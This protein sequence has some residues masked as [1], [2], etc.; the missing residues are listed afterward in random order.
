MNLLTKIRARRF[1]RSCYNLLKNEDSTEDQV[2]DEFLDEGLLQ[3]QI[4]QTGNYTLNHAQKQ[5]ERETIS[6]SGRDHKEIEKA[7]LELAYLK[8]NFKYQETF[9]EFKGFFQDRDTPRENGEENP[10]S[11]FGFERRLSTLYRFGISPKSVSFLYLA[12]DHDLL[13][14]LD[15]ACE[16][17]TQDKYVRVCLSV[18]FKP[19][20]ITQIYPPFTYKE[21][22]G[23]ESQVIQYI[24]DLKLKPYERLLK[25]DLRVKSLQLR[26]QFKAFIGTAS[27]HHRVV[28][29]IGWIKDFK[30]LRQAVSKEEF[31]SHS[32]WDL[33]ISRNRKEA[34][35]QLE[36]W[37]LIKK[38]KSLEEVA[39]ELD[40]T[41]DTAKHAF[42]K[43]YERSQNEK[44]DRDKLKK[45]FAKVSKEKF[46]EICA[47]CPRKDDFPDCF[48]TCPDALR[49][50]NQD[51][52]NLNWRET[53][54]SEMNAKLDD[55]VFFDRLQYKNTI[56]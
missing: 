23:C 30:S 36:I 49:Y 15:P 27:V 40:I 21:P 2:L 46:D 12:D 35:Q 4:D 56:R 55:D 54:L 9:K 41:P 17:D 16:L 47:S 37:K 53:P 44:Y 10:C 43:A 48:E 32:Q 26:N 29:K 28:R 50:I 18:M 52:V 14:F 31:E 34:L 8:E 7:S 45:E 5:E 19:V 6:L 13:K 42:Y 51:Q 22:V 33:D 39:Q 11:F 24:E 20:G 25:V 1:L 38:H 3:A